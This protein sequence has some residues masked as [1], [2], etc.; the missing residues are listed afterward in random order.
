MAI[1]LSGALLG[2][3]AFQNYLDRGHDH[4]ARGDY[5]AALAEYDRALRHDSDSDKA[6]RLRDQIRPYAI[7][8]ATA[9]M[10]AQLKASRYE[11]AVA[12]AKYVARLDPKKGNMLKGEIL[13]RMMAE[14]DIQIAEG[15]METAYVFGARIDK[16]FPTA[17]GV[18]KRRAIIRRALYKKSES[19]LARGD[20]A[21]AIEALAPVAR[22]DR[23]QARIVN[24]RRSHIRNAW[25]DTLVSKAKK[26][27]SEQHNGVAAAH[28]ARAYEVAQRPEDR[29][30]L[31]RLA[32]GLAR[33]AA[34][35]LAVKPDQDSQRALE[36]GTMLEHHALKL[37]G[38]RLPTDGDGATM[39]ATLSAAPMACDQLATQ[40]TA[41]QEYVAGSRWVANAQYER[42]AAKLHGSEPKAQRLANEVAT[43]RRSVKLKRAAAERC[44]RLE[45]I[46]A[47]KARD[48]AASA[49][50]AARVDVQHHE[51]RIA[52]LERRLAR[53]RRTRRTKGLV[54]SRDGIR[55]RLA[56]ERRQL[57]DAKHAY[58]QGSQKSNRAKDQYEHAQRRCKRARYDADKATRRLREKETAL[59][60]AR[61]HVGQ[62]S[63]T[64]ARTP[65][66]VREDVI[67]EF[68]FPVS[69]VTRR[70]VA[71]ST[72]E[73]KTAWDAGPSI[74][75]STADTSTQDDTHLAYPR[76]GVSS[77]PLAFPFSDANLIQRT[78]RLLVKRL[79]KTVQGQVVDYYEYMS[80]RAFEWRRDDPDAATDVMVA[81]VLAGRTHI[82]KKTLARF[83]S[84]MG[85][86]HGLRKLDSLTL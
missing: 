15:R 75:K 68:R 24:K 35:I 41:T 10:R 16:L 65:D 29:A 86:R 31:R 1:L 71:N 62:L 60:R 14:L 26:A 67:E 40:S 85:E 2:G 57:H 18:A 55:Q 17:K 7:D 43:E 23:T 49:R 77:D 38:V 5:R 4:A 36:V 22:Y 47:R 70:C 20:H 44:R 59:Q 79:V 39:V 63:A 6:R 81:L 61:A 48:A 13:E 64:L 45:Q 58:A 52:K 54:H 8:Q 25:A 53:A 19:A 30:A 12:E 66:R 9:E 78:D 76:Y 37:S 80:D 74:R 51:Q 28:Y 11:D 50:D 84:H 34:F 83:A 32:P 82:A 56:E 3:C 42:I 21:D 69:H 72:M 46:P 27:E 73:L 33:Q